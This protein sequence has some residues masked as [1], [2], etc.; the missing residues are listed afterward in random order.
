M[1]FV[2][3]CNQKSKYHQMGLLISKKRTLIGINCWNISFFIQ[4]SARNIFPYHP[5]LSNI[6]KISSEVRNL[7]LNYV[8]LIES[9]HIDKFGFLTGM[10][11]ETLASRQDAQLQ[12]ICQVGVP[13]LVVFN[14]SRILLSLTVNMT[15]RDILN[16]E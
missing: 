14:V 3:F 13:F 10:L 16:Q 1:I 6:S 5:K 8:T 11:I 9:E 4:E 2:R 7:L 15:S 12:R